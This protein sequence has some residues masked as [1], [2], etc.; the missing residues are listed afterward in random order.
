MHRK[1]GHPKLQIAQFYVNNFFTFAFTLTSV[2][3]MGFLLILSYD[4][5]L[6]HFLSYC[7]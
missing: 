7:S 5:K 2:L 3:H 6:L 4:L 1:S